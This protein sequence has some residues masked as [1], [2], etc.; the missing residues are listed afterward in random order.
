MNKGQSARIELSGGFT[1]YI[2]VQTNSYN[3]GF[4]HVCTLSLFEAGIWIKDVTA[5][6][7]YYNRTWECY[8]YQT[9]ISC[10]INDMKKTRVEALKDSYKRDQGIKRLTAARYNRDVEPMVNDDP[11]VN[12]LTELRRINHDKALF[13]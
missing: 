10:A 9:V 1:A 4:V 5:K 7:T 3:Y 6:C 13:W 11:R 8:R 2:H 12:A